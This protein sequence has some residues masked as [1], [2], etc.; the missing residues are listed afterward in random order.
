[1]LKALGTIE[2]PLRS[3][4]SLVELLSICNESQTDSRPG[5][6]LQFL[7]RASYVQAVCWIGACLADALHYAH[8]RGLVHLDVKPSNVLLAS[9]GQPMLLDFHLAKE[10]SGSHNDHLSRLGGTREYM[11]PEQR[12]AVASIAA[13]QLHELALDGRSDIYSLGVLLFESLCDTLPAA[14]ERLTA[15]EIMRGNPAITRGLADILVKCLAHNPADRFADAGELAGDLKRH[16]I[17]LPLRGVP[18]RSLGERL[19]KWQRRRPQAVLVGSVAA[20]ALMLTPF[21]IWLFLGQCLDVASRAL[22]H[23]KEELENHNLT[24]AM[25]EFE[26]GQAA[27]SWL[28]GA[29]GLKQELSNELATA[30]QVGMAETL[31]SLVEQLRHIEPIEAVAFEQRQRLAE[32]CRRIWEARHRILSADCS[33]D[34]SSQ[35]QRLRNDLLDLVLHWSELIVTLSAPDGKK[36]ACRHS[37]ELFREAE[38]LCG[39]SAIIELVRRE[40]SEQ[41]DEATTN[42]G[43]VQIQYRAS[44][45]WEHDAVGR[46][47]M[48]KGRLAEARIQFQ[49]AI[50]LEPQSFWPNLHLASCCYHL[51]DFAQALTAASI[52]VAL[53]PSS[54]ECYYNR[55]LAEQALG[56]D[57]RAARDFARATQL[58]PTLRATEPTRDKKLKEFPARPV[59]T[60]KATS[61]LPY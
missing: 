50:D 32:G 53:V 55:A 42:T 2:K 19:R 30:R 34:Q 39:P 41:C 20:V 17:D 1:M 56:Q 28:P 37:L 21:L 9:D 54:A 25:D 36:D 18:N 58:D 49:Q 8:Q 52:C 44:S 40:Y 51:E 57:E 47:L 7:H 6:A 33:N 16:I 14:S 26:R 12:Q 4:R 22:V 35:H 5:P 29:R 13:G 27:A 15:A 24:A 38:V 60:A 48:K 3:G 23:G 43:A 61:T 11:S 45:A 10:T 31:H 46:L 59:A